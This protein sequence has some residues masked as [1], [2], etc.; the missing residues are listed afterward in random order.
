MGRFSLQR[1]A[2]SERAS[3]AV[4]F[5]VEAAEVAGGGVPVAMRSEPVAKNRRT[6]NQ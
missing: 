1:T 6:C 4:V 2:G 5:S 3:S